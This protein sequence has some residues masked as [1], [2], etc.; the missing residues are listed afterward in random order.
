MFMKYN[1][2]S[3]FFLALFILAIFC[4]IKII[5]PIWIQNNYSYNSFSLNIVHTNDLHSH[6]LPFDNYHDCELDSECLGGFARIISFLKNQKSNHTLIIDA[7]DRFTGTSF[8]ALTK[9]KF[10][11]PLFQKMPYD[12]ITLG[13]HEFDDNLPETVSFLKQWHVPVVVANLKIKDSE[14]LSALVKPS[15]IVEKE[16]HKIGIIGLLTP[17]TVII[18]NPNISILPFSEVM[19]KEIEQLKKQG[20]NIIILVSHIGLDADKKLAAQFP[21]IDLIVGGHSHSLLNNG[22]TSLSADGPYPI[23]MNQGKTLIVSSGM[24]GRFVGNLK[25]IFDTEGTIIGYNGNT[26][27]MNSNI[28]SDP[29]IVSFIKN[30]QEELH[31]LLNENITFLPNSYGFTPQKNYCSENCPVGMFLAQTLHANYPEIDGVFLNSGSIRRGLPFGSIIWGDIIDSYPFD[32]DA[33]LVHLTGKELENF[34]E[35]GLK[36]YH[37]NGKTNEM[38]QTSGIQYHF[39]KD[40]KKIKSVTI[41]EKSVDLEKTYTFLT[42]SFLAQGGDGYPPHKYQK[43]GKTIREILK[44]QMQ[45]NTPLQIKNNIY[46][47]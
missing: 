37:M 6:L 18:D 36:N 10:L 19:T 44:T 21:E 9:S 33:V 32:N 15:V 11:L 1:I 28:T 20:I 8:Y 30:A 12:V 41:K 38:L 25:L 7:G 34:L 24:G 40:K 17:E 46:A 3:L 14:D 35:H 27:P 42:S 39:S 4:G 29:Q 45:K 2:K 23:V 5:F 26:I 16:H 22:P 31:S 13:N 47:E 43:T